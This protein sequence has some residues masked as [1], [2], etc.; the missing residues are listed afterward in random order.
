MANSHA[1]DYGI[2]GMRRTREILDHEG[3]RY[4]GAGED[5]EQAMAPIYVGEAPR[6][7]AVIALTTSATPESRATPTQGEI[8]GRPGVNVLRY[9]ARVTVDATT[10]STLKNSK[11]GTNSVTTENPNQLLV[12]GTI[13]NRGPNTAVEFVA[14]DQDANRLLAEI[15]SVR[16]KTDVVIVML[17]SHEPSNNSGTPADFVKQFSHAAIDAGASV[18]VGSGP[19]QLRGIEQYRGGLILYSL[20]NFAFQSGAIDPSADNLYD[21]GIDFFGLALGAVGN[22]Q[23]HSVSHPEGPV[24]WESV[25]ATMT[26]DHGILRSVQL[27]PVD[28]GVDLPLGQR[29]T[30]RLASPERGAEILERLAR[31]S[32]PFG[33]EIRVDN[34]LGLID[35]HQSQR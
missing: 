12:S 16:S 23:I 26:F 5:L 15:K 24:W 35:I 19:H 18:V 17:N 32:Q 4:A 10:F 34:G 30:P 6:R 8:Q 3:L 21:T 7:V 9:S 13:L 1:A 27:R 31:L 22:L 25:I 28:L 33:T 14:N 11:I 2:V 29:G 20:G